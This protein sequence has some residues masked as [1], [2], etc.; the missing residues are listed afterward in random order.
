[1][2]ST[3]AR[4]L[5]FVGLICSLGSWL[6]ICK[7]DTFEEIAAKSRSS[8]TVKQPYA[9]KTNVVVTLEQG[10]AIQLDVETNPYGLEKYIVYYYLDGQE[11]IMRL[12][13]YLT[14]GTI[15]GGGTKV[16]P[17]GQGSRTR[18]VSGVPYSARV[19]WRIDQ[20]KARINFRTIMDSQGPKPMP[21][22]E[23]IAGFV[24]LWSEVKYNFAFF[25]RMPDLNWDKVLVDYL[26][27]VQ[28]AQTDVEYYQVLRRCMALLKDGHTDLWGPSPTQS[29]RLPFILEPIEG[30]AVMTAV[31]DA[32]TITSEAQRKQL[33]Q[34]NLRCGEA[35]TH[36]DGRAVGDI[37][38]DDIYPYVCAST[39]QGRDLRAY[40]QLNSGPFGKE[41]TLRIK[42][43]D[44]TERQVALTCGRWRVSR[45][46]DDL[47]DLRDL[48]DGILYFNISSFG[49]DDAVK[50]VEANMDRIC[51]A[52]GLILD[53]RQ[54]GGGNSANGDALISHMTNKPLQNGRWKTRQYLPA[55]RA[56]GRPEQWYEGSPDV[57]RPQEGKR[58]L[59]PVVTL[60]GPA[61]CSAAEDFVVVFQYNGRGK[62]IG[63]PTN[64][65]TGQPLPLELPGGGGARICTKWDTYPDG[66]EFVGVGCLPDVEVIPTRADIA[67]GRDV[68][69]D[70]AIAV[71][72]EPVAP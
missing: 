54:N 23:R 66:R 40:Q 63:Q 67:A 61:T 7:A 59:G 27:Q 9:L 15:S 18:S 33:M 39:P 57:I 50:K 5:T 69:L 8:V 29:G 48:P 60:V 71:L 24:K 28:A 36:I 55:H 31:S 70:K 49:S 58:Y 13:T 41:T 20:G 34:A 46:T 44:G 42:A 14:D 35:V 62:V 11:G 53:L 26:P 25:S 38:K 6:S 4:T 30:M 19:E 45:L 2:R 51:A 43:L 32:N 1:M 52:K 64:G 68:V 3:M 22:V 47:P 37:L 21:E 10:Q 12:D 16:G 72:R 56:W 65:S 17:T